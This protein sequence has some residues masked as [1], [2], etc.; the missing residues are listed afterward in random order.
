MTNA[1]GA[2]VCF[3]SLKHSGMAA[4]ALARAASVLPKA[5]RIVCVTPDDALRWPVP[6]PAGVVSAKFDRGARLNAKESPVGVARVLAEAAQGWGWALKLDADTMLADAAWTAGVA[7]GA[8]QLACWAG[9]GRPG[10]GAAYAIGEAMAV[11]LAETY[12]TIPPAVGDEDM[13]ILARAR[14][15]AWAKGW[16][17]HVMPLTIRAEENAIRQARPGDGPGDYD[18]AYAVHFGGAY[19]PDDIAH[20]MAAFAHRLQSPTAPAASPMQAE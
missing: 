16:R 8:S 7:S 4:V 15:L 6:F 2:I 14:V 9:L 17:S 20:R 13:D 5:T 19:A 10:Y 3:S 1:P 12:R 18:G 11:A